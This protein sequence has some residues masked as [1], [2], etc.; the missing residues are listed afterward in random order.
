M[1]ARQ[2]QAFA[3]VWTH[4]PVLTL[5]CPCIGHVGIAGSLG[6]THDFGGSHY[7]SLGHMTFGVP[8][9]YVALQVESSEAAAFDSAIQTADSVFTHREHNLLSNNCHHHVA[10]AL[11]KA[12]YQHRTWTAG[13]VWWLLLRRG[14][15]V[16]CWARCKTYGLWCGIGL[17][18]LA[19]L[20]L[21]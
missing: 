11:T 13:Q 15:F 4:L 3:V 6:D 14:K 21:L 2:K 20:A 1:E 16:T 17:G 5:F 12:G 8:L 18:L 7:I 19:L 10:L 9:K